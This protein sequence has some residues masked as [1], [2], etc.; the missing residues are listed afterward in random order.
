MMKKLVILMSLS[1][2][3]LFA[4]LYD[5]KYNVNSK[6]NAS[7]PALSNLLMYGDFAKIIRFDALIFDKDTN[8]LDSKSKEELDKIVQT[9]KDYG[10]KKIIVTMIGYT[11]H[12]ETHNEKI[13]RE[14]SF[15]YKDIFP[16]VITQDQ[17]SDESLSYAQA[18]EKYL[19]DNDIR[20]D[21][22]VVENRRGDEKAFTEGTELGKDLNHRVMVT[23]YE[24]IKKVFKKAKKPVQEPMPEV[25][26][27]DLKINY[28]NDSAIIPE[29]QKHKV[30][31]FATFLKAFP[32]YN[33]TI[34]GHTSSVGSAK[35]NKDLSQA[36]AQ[37]VVDML[38]SL[39]VDSNRLNA[40]GKGEDE[41]ITTNKTKEG[42]SKNRRTI[43]ILN[44]K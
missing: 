28:A 7:S 31:A 14:S 5:Y 33:A 22:L 10:D 42:R 24:P 2:S 12:V 37:G 39:G 27:V 16:D 29:D 23:I 44:T 15:S 9:I 18:V 21:I 43:A 34:Q 3:F 36:R 8:Q 1:V 6:A 38:I 30:E 41:P 4:G 13:V 25:K 35:Y 20:K 26:M 19:L 17:S 32:K 40:I 11:K